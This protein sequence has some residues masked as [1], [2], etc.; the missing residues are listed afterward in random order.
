MLTLSSN[1]F[2]ETRIHFLSQGRTHR[3]FVKCVAL[4]LNISELLL[5]IHYIRLQ[6]L[7]MR[8]LF[9]MYFLTNHI[10]FYVH[11]CID[12]LH[13]QI[14]GPSNFPCNFNIYWFFEIFEEFCLLFEVQLLV[15][16]QEAANT[17]IGTV[18]YEV[19]RIIQIL[20]KDPEV[21]INGLLTRLWH[22]WNF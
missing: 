8:I 16:F 20:I 14:K 18:F 4:L 15:F 12:L 13:Q 7:I 11:D 1:W 3:R 5:Q 17:A 2:D 19:G 22:L 21:I 9:W 10:H 6:N